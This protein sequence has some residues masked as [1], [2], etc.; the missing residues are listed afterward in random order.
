MTQPNLYKQACLATL[1]HWVYEEK[2]LHDQFNTCAGK[3][4]ENLPDW[5]DIFMSDYSVN[6]TVVIK[7]GSALKA[8]SKSVW[9]HKHKQLKRNLYNSISE[10]FIPLVIKGAE[11]EVIQKIDN[12]DWLPSNLKNK[13]VSLLSKVAALTKPD[14][15]PMWDT[16]AKEAL[17]GS[18]NDYQSFI[19]AHKSWYQED[20][21]PTIVDKNIAAPF[22]Q[23]LINEFS[24]FSKGFSNEMFYYRAADKYLWLK[25]SP[26]SKKK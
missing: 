4:M 20:F 24:H 16:Q 5:F 13:V 7:N 23:I 2:E 8:Q 3:S 26:K 21:R 6:R 1:Y 17:G 15:F 18:F 19:D 22:I 12:Q 11:K 25:A 10:K 9:E 14:Q